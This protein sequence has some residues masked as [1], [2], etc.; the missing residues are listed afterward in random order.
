[1]V[2]RCVHNFI[3]IIMQRLTRRVSV[4]KMTNRRMK[5]S[6]FYEENDA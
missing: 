1:L 3:I 4:I 2:L 5:Q 6:Y